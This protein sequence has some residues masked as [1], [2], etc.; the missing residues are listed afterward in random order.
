MAVTSTAEAE[1]AAASLVTAVAAG[2]AA[3]AA[4][5]A[6]AAA[7]ETLAS[8]TAAS[9]WPL[10]CALMPLTVPAKIARPTK[11]TIGE[12]MIEPSSWNRPFMAP[13]LAIAT[14]ARMKATRF[15]G[16][17]RNRPRPGNG[18][19]KHNQAIASVIHAAFPA[20]LAC[21]VVSATAFKTTPCR[22][23]KVKSLPAMAARHRQ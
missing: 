8:A 12:T 15:S 7:D 9:Y 2:S 4:A 22:D 17:P 23:R 11:Y 21:T 1:A 18:T 3:L 14:M 10:L 16:Q 20:G 13:P 6:S 5:S 19:R